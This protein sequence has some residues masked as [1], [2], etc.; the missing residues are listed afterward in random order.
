MILGVSLLACLYYTSWVPV[1]A[2]VVGY[3][4]VEIV[5]LMFANLEPLTEQEVS[6][7][8]A[9]FYVFF[10]VFFG[11]VAVALIINGTSH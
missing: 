7:G 10:L 1:A 2:G 4:V 8:K 3:T 9:M 6:R 11:L 5:V